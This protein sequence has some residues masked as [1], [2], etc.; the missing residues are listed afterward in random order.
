MKIRGVSWKLGRRNTLWLRFAL[1]PL[2][3][4]SIFRIKSWWST[5]FSTVQGESGWIRLI[6]KDSASTAWWRKGTKKESFFV[7]H[8]S[9]QV[10]VLK[11]TS[12]AWRDG[13]NPKSR[14]TKS[15]AWLITILRSFFA[16]FARKNIQSILIEG[17]R[18]LSWCRS[19]YQRVTT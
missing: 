10:H 15:K 11:F 7:V 2:A 19:S 14:K 4:N 17:R 5:L 1:S 8:V 13:I 6:R 16:R 9:V 3:S 18:L 12:N